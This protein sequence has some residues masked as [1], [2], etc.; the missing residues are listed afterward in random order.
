MS[1]PVACNNDAK[2]S[3]DQPRQHCLG[4]GTAWDQPMYEAWHW[5]TFAT[6]VGVLLAIDLYVH[7]DSRQTSARSATVWTVIWIAA[8]LLFSIV[9]FSVSNTAG[10]EYLASY[11]IEKSLSLDN[12]FVFLLIFRSLRIPDEHQH[13]VLA[14]GVFGALLFR[15][16]FI[17]LGV[18]ALERW[19]WVNY[20]FGGILGL[21]ALHAFR[22]NP[23]EQRDSRLVRYLR[24]HLPVSTRTDTS[25]FITEENGSRVVTPLFVALIAIELSDVMF[26]V[27]SVPA[28]LSVTTDRFVVYSSN[29]FAILGLRA[30]YLAG[31]AYLTRFEYL[32]YGLAAVLAFAAFKIIGGDAV[33]LHPLLSVAIIV[34][35]IG[36]A[37][38]A[39]F[40]K[41]KSPVRS[42][43]RPADSSP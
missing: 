27:D 41:Q 42:E 6:S 43:R 37:V 11:A 13:T 30:L 20:V 33:H 17:F 9:P 5:V 12:M 4:T 23:N 32:H 28:A 21:A 16:I 40:F 35:C 19:G 7:R 1:D 18:A 24:N 29:A 34:C 2:G 31:H 10:H 22:E 15:G 14:W 36:A 38:G 8:G 3:A 26:A 25:E 39:S